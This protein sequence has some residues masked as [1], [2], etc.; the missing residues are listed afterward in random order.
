MGA[1]NPQLAEHPDLE[2][3][4]EGPRCEGREPGWAPHQREGRRGVRSCRQR[5]ERRNS[6]G[7]ERPDDTKRHHE[8]AGDPPPAELG[9]GDR[10]DG[11][12]V[13]R[14]REQGGHRPAELLEVS[15]SLLDQELAGL[16]APFGVPR[17]RG[18]RTETEVL[19]ALGSE[20][21]EPVLRHPRR[22]PRTGFVAGL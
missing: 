7:G 16:A 1:Y 11:H 3:A 12:L 10:L 21:I 4:G 20:T 2:R 22:A 8:R 6:L 13:T 14:T 17:R 18:K 9:P 19:Q 5:N 15:G